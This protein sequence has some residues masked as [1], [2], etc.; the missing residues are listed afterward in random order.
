MLAGSDGALRVG[1]LQNGLCM[2]S[3]VN[4]K[5]EK[6]KDAN[7]DSYSTTIEKQ[8]KTPDPCI[9]LHN[10]YCSNFFFPFTCKFLTCAMI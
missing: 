5:T 6:T 2:C 7:A 8:L 1:L 3:A 9:S 4:Y 10:N